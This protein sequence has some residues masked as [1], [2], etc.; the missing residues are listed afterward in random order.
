MAYESDMKNS[1]I[2]TIPLTSATDYRV[3]L[4]EDK[5]GNFCGVDIRQWFCTKDDSEK[6]P[7]QKGIRL[8]REN[9]VTVLDCLLK[10]I[11]DDV[12]DELIE[13]GVKLG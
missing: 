1:T 13:R 8:S 9:L 11:P 7:N 10:E 2:C 6:R 4:L 12:K 3:D 5:E